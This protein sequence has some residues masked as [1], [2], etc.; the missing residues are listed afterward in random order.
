MVFTNRELRIRQELGLTRT[1]PSAVDLSGVHRDHFIDD[2]FAT[3][4][5][6]RTDIQTREL[7][8]VCGGG[9]LDRDRALQHDP[10]KTGTNSIGIKS[11]RCKSKYSKVALAV[12]T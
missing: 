3:L 2:P 1:T 5:E 7:A 6:M 8:R 10:L 9:D 4:E 12:R 11:R